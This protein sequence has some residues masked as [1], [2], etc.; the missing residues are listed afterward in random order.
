MIVSA[1]VITPVVFSLGAPAITI[2]IYNL[3]NAI[4]ALVTHGNIKLPKKLDNVLRKFVVTPD[5]HRLHHSSDK[6]FTDSNYS[7]VVP[8]FD[9]LFKTSTR[10]PYAEI[11][12]MELGLDVLRGNKENRLDAMLLTPFIYSQKKKKAAKQKLAQ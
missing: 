6:Y 1:L 5:F 7:G 2:A 4:F 10:K 8:W 12:T 9:Y 11:P 3:V